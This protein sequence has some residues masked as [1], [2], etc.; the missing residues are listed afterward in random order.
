MTADYREEAVDD[1]NSPYD[2]S[3]ENFVSKNN[4]YILGPFDRSISQKVIPKLV[5]LIETERHKKDPKITVY[6]NSYGGAFPELLG[7][8]TLLQQAKN[9]GIKIVTVVIGR[10]VS[11]G[12]LLA[13]FGDE[14]KMYRHALNLAHLGMQLDS[15]TTNEQIDRTSKKWKWH[16][17]TILDMYHNF[18]GCP[19][20]KLEV[21]LKDD[22]GWLTP[23]EC[24]QLGFATEII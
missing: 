12:S 17:K 9:Y 21:L 2:A 6:I 19:K 20:K 11:C 3:Q 23:D 10:A 15:V 5:D 16:F 14:R 4:V 8:L 18:T 7:I 1:E 22:C 24:I 13:C